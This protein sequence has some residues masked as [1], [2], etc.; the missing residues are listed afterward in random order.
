MTTERPGTE[1][2][3]RLAR[4]RVN[5]ALSEMT[6]KGLAPNTSEAGRTT[7]EKEWL[8]AGGRLGSLDAIRNAFAPKESEVEFD[9]LT[10]EVQGLVPGAE[11]VA[12]WTRCSEEPPNEALDAD[13]RA[14]FARMGLDLDYAHCRT[15]DE[16]ATITAAKPKR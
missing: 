14:V 16:A 9:R 6:S 2:A 4:A 7:L 13:I 10:S 12:S 11:L 8:A 1:C 15:A 3:R 5:L